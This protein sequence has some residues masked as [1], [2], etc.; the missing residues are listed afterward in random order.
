MKR[1]TYS[2]FSDKVKTN[3][4]VAI[5]SDL[6][7][8]KKT[9]D[10]KLNDVI[11]TLEKIKPTHIVVPG[12]LFNVDE[13]TISGDKVTNFISEI[14]EISEVFYVKGNIEDG[15]W[16]PSFSVLPTGLKNNQNNRFHV[17]GE[18][19]EETPEQSDLNILGLRIDNDIYKM[20]EKEKIATIL[21]KYEEYLKI[22][23]SRYSKENFNILLCHDPI[24]RDVLRLMEAINGTQLNYDLVISGH[25]HGGMYPKQLKRIIKSHVEDITKYY[26]KYTKD[27]WS[28]NDNSNII[29][30]EGVTKYHSEMG[31]LEILEKKHEGTI[32]NVHILKRY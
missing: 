30:S 4:N 19:H 6:H 26:P 14:T 18:T 12:D 1:K 5:L 24:I 11:N 8:S 10:S 13:S 2:V 27:M 25:N 3:K 29:I 31:I 20:G 28:I 32:E 21:K 15:D 9:P 7:I 16:G 17:V 22:L 23:S